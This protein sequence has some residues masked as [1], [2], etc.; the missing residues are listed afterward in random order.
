MLRLLIFMNHKIEVCFKQIG[1]KVETE[2]VGTETTD[3]SY[4]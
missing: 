2:V 3:K 1:T 4:I